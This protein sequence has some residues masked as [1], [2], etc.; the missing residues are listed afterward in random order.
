MAKD[1][2]P[3]TVKHNA[4]FKVAKAI[5]EGKLVRPTQCELCG[6]SPLKK[7]S[8]Q[9]RII[10]HH[11]RGYDY[12]LDVWWICRVCNGILSKDH[13]GALTKAKARAKIFKSHPWMKWGSWTETTKLSSLP[14]ITRKPFNPKHSP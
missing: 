11:W 12:P 6:D 2:I 7:I 9:H 4:R 5:E 14:F 8:G 13:D 3:Y 10:A 1:E